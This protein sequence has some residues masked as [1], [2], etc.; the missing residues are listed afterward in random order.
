VEI[1][2]R[3]T[4]L[5]AE[6]LIV[7]KTYEAPRAGASE[8]P[9]VVL[10]DTRVTPELKQ[11]GLARDLIRNIQN[12]RKQAGLDIADRIRLR[13]ATESEPVRAAVEAFGD[14]I[15]R[16]TLAVELCNDPL[17]DS[18]PHTEVKIDGAP[19]RIELSKA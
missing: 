19:T 14:H 6:D 8:G 17:P 12:L 3:P 9:T 2:G 18:A 16:E 15:A 10:L 7:T 4:P 5:D 13:I 1:D 11:E